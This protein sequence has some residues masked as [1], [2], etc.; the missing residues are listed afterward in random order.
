MPFMFTSC[1]DHCDSLKRMSKFI[2]YIR[3]EW[4]YI[5]RQLGMDPTRVMVPRYSY[6]E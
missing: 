5:K 2:L 1:S 6:H 3:R 4:G